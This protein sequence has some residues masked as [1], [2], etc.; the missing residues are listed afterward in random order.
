[1]LVLYEE[2]KT[3]T[4]LISSFNSVQTPDTNPDPHITVINAPATPLIVS[5][6]AFFPVASIKLQSIIQ[7]HKK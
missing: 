2:E 3:N 7:T 1:M 6:H 5:I 4:F